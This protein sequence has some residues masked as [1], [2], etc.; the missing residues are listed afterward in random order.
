VDTVTLPS[1]YPD[2]QILVS[3]LGDQSTV[4]IN[5]DLGLSRF[6]NDTSP[7]GSFVICK[8]RINQ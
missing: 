1:K 6:I 4:V 3:I 2:R 8:S 5:E 7:G